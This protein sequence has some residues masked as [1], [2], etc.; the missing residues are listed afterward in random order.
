MTRLLA[1]LLIVSACKSNDAREAERAAERVR[2]KTM[3]L[4]DP[5]KDV[6][7]SVKE[8]EAAQAAFATR[9]AARLHHLEGRFVVLATVPE[10]ITRM[11]HQRQLTPTQQVRLA[12]R[13]AALRARIEEARGVM[14]Q[15]RA[16]DAAEWN[17][18]DDEA[19]RALAKVDEA[20][21]EAID[22]LGEAA[23]S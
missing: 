15:L 16:T 4:A 17:G 18:R 22:V 23:G 1:V 3:D 12:E 8:L 10:L 6:A 21:D 2:A 7:T 19:S 11:A 14:A 13:L 9:K 5:P 20:R